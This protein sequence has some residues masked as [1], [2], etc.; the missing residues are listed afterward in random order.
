MRNG[1]LVSWRPSNLWEAEKKEEH[2]IIFSWAH[3]RGKPSLVP[4]PSLSLSF[5][6]TILEAGKKEIANS[7]FSASKSV[8]AKESEREGLGTR[9]RKA[10][11]QG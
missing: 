10:W 8:G 3:R 6:P 4:R 11:E 1:N 7:F 9:L 2:V 5:A